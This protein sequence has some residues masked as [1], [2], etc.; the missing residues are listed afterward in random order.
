[1]GSLHKLKDVSQW[2]T[3]FN[4]DYYIYS[5]KLDGISALLIYK[6]EK[7]YMYTRGDGKYG[8]DIT[9]LTKYLNLPNINE[10]IALRGELIMSK[11]NY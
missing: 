10:N 3:K 11:N 6:D 4:T 9:K 2:I 8:E 1:M 5:D 7:K